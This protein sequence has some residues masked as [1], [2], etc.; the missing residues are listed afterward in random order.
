MTSYHFRRFRLVPAA[1][2]PIGLST[3]RW[4]DAIPFL[5][6]VGQAQGK[7]AEA[8]SSQESLASPKHASEL[9]QR[10]AQKLHASSSLPFLQTLHLPVAGGRRARCEVFLQSSWAMKAFYNLLGLV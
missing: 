9:W 10:A 4:T 5:K 7:H 6:Q 8:A 1:R 2:W 3:V